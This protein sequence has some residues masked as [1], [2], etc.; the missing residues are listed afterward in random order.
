MKKT[1]IK[2]IIGNA[3]ILLSLLLT[4]CYSVFNGGTGGM[5][6]DAES[7]STP[8]AGIAYVDVYAYTDSDTRDSDY[9]SWR[10]GTVFSPSNNY[11]GHT[12]TDTNGNFTI[13]N[14]VWKSDKPE[15]GK[16]ADYTTIYL[17]FYHENYGLT[18]G[19]T[20][21]TSDSTSDTVYAELTSIKKTTALT[22]NIIDVSNSNR[23][24]DPVLVKVSVPQNTDSLP[25]A[26]AKVYEQLVSGNGTIYISYPRWKNREDKAEGL[27]NQP[28]ANIS[29]AQSTDEI[30][31]KACANG[32]N[33]E[34]NYAF[35]TDNK[36]VKKLIHNSNY[37]ISL[38]GKATR[39]YLPNVSGIYGD[40][41]D[42]SNDGIKIKMKA[43]DS[44]GNY[45]I[46]C[47]EVT[48]NA[49][50]LG[51]SGNQSHG[52]FNELGNGCFFTDTSY[53]EKNKIIEVKFY[54]VGNDNIETELT[55]SI[56]SF[57]NDPSKSYTV[58]LQ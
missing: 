40:S 18:K 20:V 58:S 46:D 51:N 49:K 9:N 5:I 3:A 24:S 35:Y 13:S 28:E 41:S 10:E 32:D 44:D 47:G 39:I 22:I 36:F 31:W 4:S 43:K 48:T 21:I 1:F 14:I 57:L 34:N 37:E 23:I 16:D 50:D 11:Y 6:V 25:N 29:Y 2:R 12:S 15:F 7:T 54:K 26:K 42:S 55:A 30:T 38:Y 53:T 27:E 45:T 33:D 56:N 8:K 52:N 19:S 17:L